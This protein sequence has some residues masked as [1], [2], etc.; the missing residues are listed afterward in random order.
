MAGAAPESGVK[1]VADVAA[2]LV[3]ALYLL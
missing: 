1:E 3:S 2:Y